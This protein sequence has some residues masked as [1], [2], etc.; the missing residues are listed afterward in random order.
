MVRVAEIFTPGIGPATDG[1]SG[2]E[3][4]DVPHAWS[5]SVAATMTNSGGYLGIIEITK[6]S[7][8]SGTRP[9]VQTRERYRTNFRIKKTKSLEPRAGGTWLE[10]APEV[11]I[12]RS[13]YSTMRTAW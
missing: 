1:L 11:G 13:H 10:T 8:A 4:F 9:R 7:V 5:P 6:V 3:L 12:L 2:F